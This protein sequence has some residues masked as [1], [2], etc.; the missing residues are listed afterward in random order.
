MFNVA[1]L[2]EIG[3][4]KQKVLY[5][6][7]YVS[8]PYTTDTY[9]PPIL[10]FRF[11]K[12]HSQGI[13]K[14]RGKYH[15]TIDLLFDWFGLVCCANKKTKIV[16]RHTADSKPVKQE[17]NSTVILPLLVFPDIIHVKLPC[18]LIVAVHATALVTAEEPI[19]ELHSKGRLLSLSACI[20]L[21]WK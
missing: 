18:V 19:V 2:A 14:G 10:Y 4:Y 15:C 21:V 6:T 8:V 13:P 11:L 17:V 7:F 12:N 1:S 5:T 9:F 20:R 3:S 16:S